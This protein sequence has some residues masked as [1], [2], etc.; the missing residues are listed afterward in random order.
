MENI[1]IIDDEESIREN[2]AYALKREGYS[3]TLFDNGETALDQF[4]QSKPDLI[5]LDILMPRMDGLEFCKK[6][7]TIDQK[8]P[9]IFLSSKDEVFDRVLGLELGGDDYLC[10]PFSVRELVSRVKVLL[11]RVALFNSPEDSKKDES[12]L[13]HGKLK[14]HMEAGCCHYEENQIPLTITE[15]R[16]LHSLISSPGIIHSRDQLM[17]SAFPEDIYSNDRAIDSHIKR[18]RKKLNEQGVETDII[19]SVYGMGYRLKAAL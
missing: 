9:I 10:K 4:N 8:I 3:P 12:F 1:F 17:S 5:I 7:R 11:R 13:H 15:A 18:L 16:I 14:L 6:I 2:V 19:E